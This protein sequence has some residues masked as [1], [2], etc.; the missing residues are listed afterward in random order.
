[1]KQFAPKTIVVGT[2]FSAGSDAAVAAAKTLAR[3]FG[4]DL[5]LIYAYGLPVA[6]SEYGSYYDPALDT[7]LRDAAVEDLRKY[8]A[9]HCGDMTTRAKV[10]CDTPA[11]ALL[12]AAG[13]ADMIVVGTHGRSGIR[14]LIL[15]SVAEGVLHDA[16]VPVLTVRADAMLSMR[17]ILCPVTPTDEGRRALEYAAS[18]ADSFQSQLVIG[19]VVADGKEQ[20]E[21]IDLL[22]SVP[23]DVIAR[24]EYEAMHAH[25]D[26]AARLEEFA[27][28][29]GATIVVL[30]AS[31]RRFTDTSVVNQ[32]A[33]VVV[34]HSTHS[35]LTVSA[36]LAEESAEATERRAMRVADVMTV[37][38][39][40]CPATAT[41]SEVAA[42][43]R[44]RSCGIVPLVDDRRAV[45]G[46]VTDRD[47]ACHLAA[48]GRAANETPVRSIMST[49]VVTV[50]RNESV[51]AV[52]EIMGQ[53]KIW[54]IP[55]T[56]PTGECVGIVSVA[57][58]APFRPEVMS[59][60]FA[61]DIARLRCSKT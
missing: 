33:S 32:S 4:S 13:P 49:P 57:D 38:P 45:V 46:V 5:L 21:H 51:D 54:R 9:A 22:E 10:V 15:G 6:A 28:T 31:H 44:D 53:K 36:P 41:V 12:E 35:I 34:R 42:T 39:I 24:A 23:S 59:F 55:V 19:E 1:M 40:V 30:G 60:V 50:P 8:V 7:T 16:D 25:G 18:L 17:R 11:R 48:S 14:R 43:M 47:I 58:L 2:D 26:G 37:E 52:I 27:E 3:R 61:R 20:P 29:I 56:E